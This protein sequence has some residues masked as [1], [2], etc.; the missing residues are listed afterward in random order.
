MGK[1]ILWCQRATCKISR[2]PA[3]T[4]IRGVPFPR[5]YEG[6]QRPADGS[7]YAR[8]CLFLLPRTLSFPVDNNS[9][10][11]YMFAPFLCSPTAIF[12]QSCCWASE[13]PLL[14]LSPAAVTSLLLGPQHRSWD[15]LCTPTTFLFPKLNSTI[16]A[17]LVTSTF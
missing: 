2:V 12:C 17:F 1:T 8:V 4:Q 5:A 11:R 3:V 7:C 16:F 15:L 13:R 6:L 14:C 9:V 10:Y